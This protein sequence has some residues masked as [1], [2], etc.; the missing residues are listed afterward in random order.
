ML[1]FGFFFGKRGSPGFL[2]GHSVI[3][4][5]MMMYSVVKGSALKNSRYYNEGN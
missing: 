4:M 2:L 3:I 1:V 5:F